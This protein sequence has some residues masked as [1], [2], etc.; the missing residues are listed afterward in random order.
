MIQSILFIVVFALWSVIVFD[1]A[2][3]VQTTSSS[4]TSESGGPM[5]ANRSAVYTRAYWMVHALLCLCFDARLLEFARVNPKFSLL[6]ETFDNMLGRLLNFVLVLVMLILIFSGEAMI[7]FGDRLPGFESYGL[8]VIQ[9]IF[10]ALGTSGRDGARRKGGGAGTPM[11][12]D[13]NSLSAASEI[14]PLFYFPFI[15]L[16]TCVVFNI[17]V[18]IIGDSYNEIKKRQDPKGPKFEG[19][20]SEQRTGKTES[21]WYQMKRGVHRRLTNLR[22]KS[23]DPSALSKER[24]L[25]LCHNLKARNARAEAKAKLETAVTEAHHAEAALV[26]AA[27]GVASVKPGE[28]PSAEAGPAHETR[29]DDLVDLE[30]LTY[31]EVVHELKRVHKDGDAYVDYELHSIL[32]ISLTTSLSKNSSVYTQRI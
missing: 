16:I 31:N 10:M 8:C 6:A 30:C 20:P 28:E 21:L 13:Y 25:K 12:A 22:L 26:S 23:E 15:F 32:R 11:L 2:A 19:A 27:H 5:F 18:A 4:I 3:K 9:C 1:P 29:T 17:T 14:A 7:L 24:I